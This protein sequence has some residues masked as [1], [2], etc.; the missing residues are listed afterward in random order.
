[1]RREEKKKRPD[2]QTKEV[3]G[4]RRRGRR[5]AR[6]LRK[7]EEKKVDGERSFSCQADE[8]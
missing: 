1:M 3:Y 8:G 6:E 4:E 5:V 7:T 2:A